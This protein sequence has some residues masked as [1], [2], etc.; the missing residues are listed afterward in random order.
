MFLFKGSSSYNE[1][2]KPVKMTSNHNSASGRV[3]QTRLFRLQYKPIR[4]DDH[5]T[6]DHGPF[7]RPIR[8]YIK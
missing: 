7:K 2:F 8:G 3:S 6:T 5:G 4:H 1:S